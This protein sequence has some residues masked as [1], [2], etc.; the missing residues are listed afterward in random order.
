MLTTTGR[1]IIIEAKIGLFMQ[2]NKEVT[3]IQ[4]EIHHF[5]Q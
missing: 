4:I 3:E 2:I 1:H 5:W